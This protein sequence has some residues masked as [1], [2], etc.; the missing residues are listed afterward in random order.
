MKL[1]TGGTDV[2]AQERW[3]AVDAFA[4]A[5]GLGVALSAAVVTRGRGDRTAGVETTPPDP[6]ITGNSFHPARTRQGGE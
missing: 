5:I 1:E 3:H 2:A 6:T 4:D